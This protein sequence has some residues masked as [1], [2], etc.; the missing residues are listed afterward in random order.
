[1]GRNA[2]SSF[3]H[4][5]V[6]SHFSFGD[7]A[8]GIDALVGRAAELGM[9]ALALTDH[10]GLYGAIRFYQAARKAG[11]RPIVGAEVVVEA[12]GIAHAGAGTAECDLPPRERLAYPPPA[13]FGRG[14]GYG[15]FHL[16]LLVRDRAGYR[17]LCRLLSRAHVRAKG[18]PSLVTLDDLARHSA[19]LIG[20]SGCPGGEVGAAVLAGGSGRARAALERLA[21]CFEPGAFYVELMHLLTPDSPRY[22]SS[23]TSLAETCG[24][25]VVATNNVHYLT[26]A[27]HRVH[28]VL[29][30]VSARMSLPG[31]LCRPNA[32]LWLKPAAEMRR[33]F[34]GREHACDATLEIAGRCDLDLGLGEFHFP[35]ADLPAGITPASALARRSHEGL[36]WRYRPRDAEAHARL[37][38]ELAII[39]ELGFSE[40]FLIV[41]E[42]VRF[43]KERGIRC[44]GR[45]SAGDSIV[46]YVLGITDA[47]PIA[48]N[49]LF[50]RFLNPARRQM[51]D[52]DVDFDSARRDEVIDFIYRRFGA[53]HVAM[54]ATV[55]TMT[56][57]SAVRTAAR[58]FGHPAAE[59]N[60]LSRHLPWVSARTIR[61]VL[62]TYPEC[63]NHPLREGRHE[64]ILEVAEQLDACP[65]HLGT[66]LGG[67]I[68]TREPIDTWTPLQ[69]A[70]K[71]VV[72]SQ[73]DKDDVEAL[74]LVKMDILG[75]RMHSAI[76]EAVELARARVG[77]EAVPEP[78]ELTPNDPRV[79]DLIARAD[80]VGVFQLESSG[81]RNLNTRLRAERFDDIVAAISLFRPGPLEAEM[82]TPFIRRRHGIEPVTV[83]HPAMA[84]V[85]SDSYGVIVYQ[86]Q[87]LLV[88]RAVAGF[89]LAEADSLRRA[90]TK[91]RSRAE[92]AAIRGHF[93]DRAVERGVDIIVAEEVFRQLEGFAAYGFNKAHAACF[94]IVSYASAWLRTYF[95]AELT[96]AILNNEPMGF[97]TPRLVVN[98]A[99]RHGIGLL[100]PHVNESAARYAVE[101]DG[102]A[103]RVGLRD[104]HEMSARLLG[105]IERERGVRPFR[106]L[107]DF[108]RRSRATLAEAGSLVRIGALDALGVSEAGRPPTRDEML[109]LL[110][111]LK[112]TVA[113]ESGATDDVLLLAP[114]P[115][116]SPEDPSHPSGW[117]PARRLSAELELLGLSLTC[118][119]LELAD[120]DLRARGVTFARDLRELP[121]GARVRVCGVRERAQTPRTRSGR[122]TCF[123]TLEDATGL[124]DVV[125]FEDTLEKAGE[126]IVK[127][128]CY[129]V[130]GTLQNNH[131]R[132]LA[133]VAKEVAP[134][135][136]RAASGSPVR[137][138]RG[139]PSG[140]MGPSLGGAGAPE[141]ESWEVAG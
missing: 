5:H 103:I 132:G 109:A 53:E 137:L 84:E 122:R 140:P 133:I 16:T 44:S 61:D 29:A 60:A 25:P 34:A 121:D 105:A 71:G 98:D 9:E 43:A 108:L 125:V 55:N 134:Y 50:E 123:L 58:A 139:V 79:Y 118:H 90:M 88:A 30:S 87:V 37:A 126:T 94:A 64:R 129:L 120:A 47:D 24:L 65:M 66:H 31:P 102:T 36:A 32:E 69:W 56:A 141:E 42:I 76:S 115:T 96:C 99:R 82:I 4:L 26:P 1:M 6:H 39:D 49:L 2:N 89:D 93:L 14:A 77:E 38:R 13:G 100:A 91:G 19:G 62:A 46:S 131:E 28:D 110:P 138:R 113:R 40:Y 20:M 128:R 85:L 72:V 41:D 67:F 111:E 112:A 83:P 59:I 21:A 136:V 114:G 107:G 33:L 104:V 73:Y 74:G 18:E 51:P 116:R 81:Q 97:Y 92:M 48:Y 95:P 12:A 8:V 35:A 57:R 127:H 86:E 119:P 7:G 130:E 63:A 52:I 124:L 22:L 54:V 106:D 10:Q 3:V 23:L 75:L 135:V 27:G 78:F 68:I 45:G 15:G 11:I 101:R 70:A 117:L 80:T 17:S